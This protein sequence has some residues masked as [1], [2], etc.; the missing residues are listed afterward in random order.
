[1]HRALTFSEHCIG[2]LKRR[3]PLVGPTA[4]HVR[5]PVTSDRFQGVYSV[6]SKKI[7]HSQPF[8]EAGTTGTTRTAIG[9]KGR[10]NDVVGDSPTQW[11]EIVAELK[12]HDPL[13]EFSANRWQTL[14]DDARIFLTS[15]G[16]TAHSL[17]WN[18]LDLFGVYPLAPTARYDLIGLILLLRGDVVVALTD[19]LATIRRPSGACLNYHRSDRTGAVCLSKLA[20]HGGSS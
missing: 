12:R 9:E 1:M 11:L 17:G 7:E 6:G 2:L 15:W 8:R 14:I 4:G 13:S 20:Q 10:A 16:E 3:G 18:D 19:R 5:E